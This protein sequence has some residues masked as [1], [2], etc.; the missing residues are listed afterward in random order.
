M[1]ERN[2]LFDNFEFLSKSDKKKIF[3]SLKEDIK[4]SKLL[5]DLI[6][7]NNIPTDSL[8]D[9][10]IDLKKYLNAKKNC[11]NCPGLDKCPNRPKGHLYSLDYYN[12]SIHTKLKTCPKKLKELSFLKRIN[13]GIIWRDYPDELL[14][15]DLS[16][17][18]PKDQRQKKMIDKFISLYE[19]N[20]NFPS[21]IISS[22]PGSTFEGKSYIVT[23]IFNTLLHKNK[24][25]GA[26]IN[27]PT[28]ILN[29]YKNINSSANNIEENQYKK[30]VSAIQNSDVVVF[31]DIGDESWKNFIHLDTLLPLLSERKKQKKISIFLLNMPIEKI[32]S[33]EKN[34]DFQKL[35]LF[36]NKILSLCSG[37][38]VRIK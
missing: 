10:S 21:L 20:N 31:E 12:Y 11:M 24:M 26:Y 32:Y 17:I 34:I 5:M 4:K 23:A 33:N 8:I 14:N 9:N 35:K 16:N 3:E 36:K 28:L 29:F 6:K 19:A 15:I 1:K 38:I 13:Q 18:S 22:E 30:M 27:I 7:E 25:D 37:N 2:S